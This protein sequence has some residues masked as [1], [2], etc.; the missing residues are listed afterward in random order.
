MLEILTTVKR[1]LPCRARLTHYEAFVDNRRGHWDDWLPDD[2]EEMEFD[3]LPLGSNK[4]ADWLWKAA[5]EEDIARIECEL[6]QA[7]RR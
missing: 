4:P 3:L 1:G 7:V 2:E 6:L 5:S